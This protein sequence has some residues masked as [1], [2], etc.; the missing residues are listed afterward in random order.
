MV[1]KAVG[2][3]GNVLTFAS[4]GSGYRFD[5]GILRLSS[6]DWIENWFMVPFWSTNDASL[7]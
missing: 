1:D 5:L 2:R 3:K 4:N 7:H 6:H